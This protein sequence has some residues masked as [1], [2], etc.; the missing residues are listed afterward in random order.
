MQNPA[1][2]DELADNADLLEFLKNEV[3]NDSLRLEYKLADPDARPQVL[4][5]PELLKEIVEKNPSISE[6][7]AE[8]D[9]RLER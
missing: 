7:L 2:R 1:Q 6:L 5:K 4:T 3:G 8:F 9:C